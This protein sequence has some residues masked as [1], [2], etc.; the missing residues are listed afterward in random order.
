MFSK[1]AMAWIADSR[2]WMSTNGNHYTT[3]GQRQGREIVWGFD[4]DIS[5]YYLIIKPS[6]GQTLTGIMPR[7]T[8]WIV[9]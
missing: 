5:D 9:C 1:E 6:A 7:Q 4:N 3:D 2:R 8:E